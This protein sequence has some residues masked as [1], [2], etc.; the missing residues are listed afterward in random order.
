LIPYHNINVAPIPENCTFFY[1]TVRLC[2]LYAYVI[3]SA[4]SK[5]WWI[6]QP[7][8][9]YQ[10]CNSFLFNEAKLHAAS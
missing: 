5:D 9:R 1:L 2:F 7:L 10:I 8:S 6:Q 4:V 3:L